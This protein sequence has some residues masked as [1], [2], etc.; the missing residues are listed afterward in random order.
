MSASR[1]AFAVFGGA[2]IL[3]GCGKRE[4]AEILQSPATPASLQKYWPLPDFTLTQSDGQSLRLADLKGKVWVADFFYTS[5]PGPCPVLTS[6][7]GEVQK[8]L[9]S[10]ADVR[11]VSISVDPEKDTTE[12]LQAYAKRF[13]AGPHWSFCT[14]DKPAI[15]VLAHDGF[16]LPIAEGTPESGP[17]THSTRMVLVDRTGTVRGFYEGT[18]EEGVQALVRDAGQLLEEK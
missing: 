13:N 8:A 5:C 12:A 6:K 11:L 2:L 14:G 1:F 16:K 17:V 3:A 4:A 9:A 10:N 15:I 18:S 7:L